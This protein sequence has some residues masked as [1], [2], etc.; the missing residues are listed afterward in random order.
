MEQQPLVSIITPVY[1]CETFLHETIESVLAQTYANWELWLINDASSDG[2][3]YIAAQFA[4]ADSRIKLV[5]LEKNGGA[6]V[7]RNKGLEKAEGKYVAFLDGDDLWRPQKLERQVRFMEDT[8]HLFSFTSY[9]IMREDGTER[10][11]VVEAPSVVT[12]E[13][14]LSNTIIGCLT[15]MLNQDALGPLQMPTIRTRQ[16]FMLW[17]SILKKGYSAY[18]IKEELAVYRKVGN[19]I[20]SNKWQA[21]KRNWEIYRKHEEL[22]WLKACRVFAGYAWN[23][24]KKL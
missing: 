14:L 5:D 19:S 4:E 9:R 3:K 7:A 24:M 12:Y 16:D 22:P 2:S 21:A 18:G 11:K 6:A 10:S 15:V 20:S 17:L 8:G 23:G 1:N 13:Q